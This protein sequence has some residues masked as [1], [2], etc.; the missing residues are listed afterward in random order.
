MNHLY[1]HRLFF[2]NN[3]QIS[4]LIYNFLTNNNLQIDPIEIPI[5]NYSFQRNI[6]EG[7]ELCH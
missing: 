4:K 6:H 5:N 7:R 2:T 1:K 3:S